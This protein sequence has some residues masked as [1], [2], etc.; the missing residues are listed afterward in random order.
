LYRADDKSKP[1]A[2]GKAIHVGWQAETTSK[3]PYEMTIRFL[4]EPGADGRPSLNPDTEFE[5]MSVKLPEMFRG[6]FKPGLQLDE[7]LGEKLA[8][9]SV[10]RA[11][12]ATE[13]KIRDRIKVLKWAGAEVVAFLRA[14]WSKEK[15]AELTAEE[16]ADALAK[17]EKMS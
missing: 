1:G 2:G 10:D 9:W 5:R 8:R 12:S 11:P 3:L 4:L 17:L 16:Q 13:A 7:D 14:N 15:L 6:W